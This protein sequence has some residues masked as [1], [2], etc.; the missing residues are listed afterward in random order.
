[1]SRLRKSIIGPFFIFSL[2][3]S[4]LGGRL[5]SL[6]LAAQ[7]SSAFDVVS[8]QAVDL[9]NALFGGDEA[10]AGRLIREKAAT[11]AQSKF[12]AAIQGAKWLEIDRTAAAEAAMNK[13]ISILR[14]RKLKNLAEALVKEKEALFDPTVVLAAGWS[15]NQVYNRIFKHDK[16]K[17]DTTSYWYDS[18]PVYVTYGETSPVAYLKYN[19][20]RTAGYYQK[21]VA[22]SEDIPNIPNES[23]DMQ[24]AWSRD[25][26]WGL[27]MEF[28]WDMQRKDPYWLTDDETAYGSYHLPWRSAF[29]GQVVL[30]APFSKDFGPNSENETEIKRAE[31]GVKASGLEAEAVINSILAETETAFWKLTL[32]QKNL[33]AVL[34]NIEI[35]AAMRDR[36]QRFYQEREA[37]EYDLLTAKAA[38]SSVRVRE[39]T[40]W[41]NYFRASA[42]LV[43]YTDLGESIILI[44]VGYS[45]ILKSRD[46]GLSEDLAALDPRKNPKLRRQAVNIKIAELETDFRRIQTRPDVTL[47]ASMLLSQKSSTYGFSELGDSIVNLMISPDLLV[48][49]Y[50]ININYPV[51]NRAARSALKQAELSAEQ[52]KLVKRSI[53]NRLNREVDDGFM[54]IQNA[55]KRERLAEKYVSL[56]RSVYEKALEL[57]ELREAAGY[58]A[59]IKSN[60]LLVAELTLISARIERLSAETSLAAAL[61]KMKDRIADYRISEDA[62]EDGT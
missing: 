1:M 21:T 49:N 12:R 3:L 2:I 14:A 17:K 56:S 45:A 8:T 19:K 7:K 62:A 58:E 61:G 36:T 37:T 6:G 44:P 28:N 50:K 24:A 53:E 20:P 25:I 32:A 34:K 40:A 9:D 26:F 16:W 10:A 11:L 54:Q 30:P 43:S 31:L 51:L 55:I 42:E 33:L 59:V 39:Q 52:Q 57:N 60:E 18:S 4:F 41:E 47:N 22:A 15:K 27:E 48:Q 46:G 38:L 23:L 5:E 13:N 29:F 35:A